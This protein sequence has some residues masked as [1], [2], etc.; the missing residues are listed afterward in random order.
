MR[1]RLLCVLSIVVPVIGWLE[2]TPISP[3]IVPSSTGFSATFVPSYAPLA[4]VDLPLDDS[5][6][7]ALED[8]T[9]A[10]IPAEA[11]PARETQTSVENPVSNPAPAPA[12]GSIVP[13]VSCVQSFPAIPPDSLEQELAVVDRINAERLRYGLLPL[14]PASE[15][16]QSARLHSREMAENSLL[17]HYG[18]DGS[19]PRGRMESA[20]YGG[21]SWGEI[22]EWGYGD[23]AVTVGW[24]MNSP[25]HRANILNP[26]FTEF[27][28]GYA[29]DPDSCCKH[30]W[31]VNFG[32]ADPMW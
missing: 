17:S 30:F 24:W 21:R 4:L 2:G 11:Q 1:L 19:T 15:L 7:E 13:V 31:T 26:R 10:Q 18:P 12:A 23:D 6:S 16:T 14:T 22:I 25:V 8:A 27:G 3:F 29:Y 5:A 28:V 9:E 20:C 32:S